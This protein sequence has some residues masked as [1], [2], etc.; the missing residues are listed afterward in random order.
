MCNVN[1]VRK[2]EG[3]NNCWCVGVTMLGYHQT[4]HFPWADWAQSA[5]N[6]QLQLTIP[7][8]N[9]SICDWSSWLM[10]SSLSGEPRRGLRSLLSCLLSLRRQSLSP[11]VV[12]RI[13]SSQ[14]RGPAPHHPP[15]L[16]GNIVV[17]QQHFSLLNLPLWTICLP[18]CQH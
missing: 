9:Q 10:R 7:I 15:A 6:T 14:Q 18:R 5:K 3:G 17:I 2:V 12:R 1:T 13:Y 4:F 16:L 11:E 8:K